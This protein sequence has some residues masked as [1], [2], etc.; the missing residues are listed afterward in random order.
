MLVTAKHCIAGVQPGSVFCT[1]NGELKDKS[2]GAG[3]FGMLPPADAVQVYVGTFPVKEQPVARG[4]VI[5]A[6]P[7]EDGRARSSDRLG[8]HGRDSP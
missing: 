5:R 6:M 8:S 4:S 7:S 2:T 1:G 3:M